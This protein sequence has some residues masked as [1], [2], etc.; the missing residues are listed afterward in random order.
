MA[1]NE[2]KKRIKTLVGN[3][4]ADIWTVKTVIKLILQYTGQVSSDDVRFYIKEFRPSP[5][6][7][8]TAFRQLVNDGVLKKTGTKKTDIKSSKGRDI[9]VFQ[10]A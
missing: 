1:T 8:G 2:L 4:P 6:I 10:P 7:V 9:A 5:A 3:V